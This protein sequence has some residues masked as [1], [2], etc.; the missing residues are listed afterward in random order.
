MRGDI[1]SSDANRLAAP[2]SD[3]FAAAPG[4][5]SLNG[6]SE[7]CCPETPTATPTTPTTATIT[8]TTTAVVNYQ[9]PNVPT[10]LFA[11]Y[12]Y[13][14][15]V[16]VR[17]DRLGNDVE[18]FGIDVQPV[19]VEVSN[20]RE[21]DLDLDQHAVQLVALP[22]YLPL[23][24]CELD[25]V[26]SEYYPECCRLVQQATGARQVIAFDH[27]VR[28]EARKGESMGGGFAVQPPLPLV[29]GDYTEAS[30]RQRL[31][32]LT[33]PPKQNDTLRSILGEKP[34]LEEDP[35][36]LLQ[37]RFCIINVWRSLAPEPIERMPLGI[38]SPGSVPSDDIVVHEIHYEDRI[39]ENYNARHGSGHKWW[40]FP[41]MH[42]EEALLFKCWDSAG[43]FAQHP[44][45]GVA[46]VPATFAFHS[47]LEVPARPDAPARESIEVRTIA[48]F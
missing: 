24:Y 44:P 13:P 23:D 30:A 48:I 5:E 43:S 33:R 34:P 14:P 15:K 12:T 18:V 31:R 41:R 47:A 1:F 6:A 7:E 29:H 17:R 25:Q 40:M 4:V 45:A 27:N 37:R 19:S 20:G 28:S 9:S 22:P 10:G 3:K 36:E 38:L 35:E 8:T 11:E 32:D 16:G 21:E 2:N 26:L 39:G 46:R 42:R